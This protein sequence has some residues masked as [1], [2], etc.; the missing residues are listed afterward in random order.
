MEKL[1]QNSKNLTKNLQ[2]VLRDLAIQ[3]ANKLKE[4]KTKYFFSHKKE[5]DTDFI[6]TFIREIDSVETFLF[7]SVGDEKSTGNIVLYGEEKAI[8]DLSDK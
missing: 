4:N 8:S 2:T 1:I 5:G 6:N 3:E 7:L